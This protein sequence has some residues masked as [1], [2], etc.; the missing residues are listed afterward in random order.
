MYIPLVL[1][2][3]K[4]YTSEL[5]LPIAIV[6]IIEARRTKTGDENSRMSNEKLRTKIYYVFVSICTYFPK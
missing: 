3:Y 2:F 5:H 1:L 4:F 6:G